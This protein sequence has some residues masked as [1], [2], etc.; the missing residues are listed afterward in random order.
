MPRINYHRQIFLLS[1]LIIVALCFIPLPN[2]WARNSW[3][4][5]YEK[6]A[7]GTTDIHSTLYPDKHSRA[8]LWLARDALAKGD[9]LRALMLVESLAEQGDRQA[10]IIKAHALVTRGEFSAAVQAWIQASDFTSLL[11]AA[12][13]A[14]DDARLDDAWMA[15][16]AAQVVDPE[17]GTLPLVYFLWRSNELES[18]A[19]LLRQFLNTHPQATN[20]LALVLQLG[21]IL[22]AQQSWTEAEAVYLQLLNEQP[23]NVAA[24]I[25]LGWVYYLRGDGLEL[26]ID[27]FQ[28][29]ISY[30]PQQGDGYFAMGQILVKE[31]CYSEADTWF[32]RA[33]ERNPDELLWWLTR[34][35]AARESGDLVL[36][37]DIYRQA[38]TQFPVSASVYYEMAWTYRLADLPDEAVRT[39]EQALALAMP[40]PEQYYV[41]AGQIYEWAGMEV[42]AIAVFRKV[43]EENPSNIAAQQGL[44]R[45]TP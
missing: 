27:E 7:L 24:H 1:L 23:E 32:A 2:L 26:A 17:T 6:Y 36:A 42:E 30:A 12:R 10:L 4:L 25:G 41:R 34:A 40:P 43:L 9:P 44:Q 20:R 18:A 38:E 8:P 39:I 19:T 22:R 5:D 35:N 11:D 21:S 37:I 31:T 33:I 14:E 16:R 29:A 45:L 13:A 15:F 28:K 3:S